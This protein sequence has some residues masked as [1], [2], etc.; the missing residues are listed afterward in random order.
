[1]RQ[2]PDL[3][4]VPPAHIHRISSDSPNNN[5]SPFYDASGERIK[6]LAKLILQRQRVYARDCDKESTDSNDG[7]TMTTNTRITNSK[8]QGTPF[9]RRSTFNRL[10]KFKECEYLPW[11]DWGECPVKCGRGKVY[12]Q[13]AL[14]DESVGMN[15]KLSESKYCYG[16]DCP[17]EEQ[18]T[19]QKKM[20][21]DPDCETTEWTEWSSCSKI[22][23][24]GVRTRTR[25]FVS[26]RSKYCR[27]NYRCIFV[28]FVYIFH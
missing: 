22:C 27:V 15:C 1:M 21:T 12:R 3:K 5:L 8:L 6:P 9:A 24:G 4:T 17:D 2:S 28:F 14:K 23:D 16:N 13:R 25:Q 19:A 20:Y 11:E 18:D 7:N 26:R 10:Q